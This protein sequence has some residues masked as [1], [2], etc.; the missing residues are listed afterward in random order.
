[1][2]RATLFVYEHPET[3]GIFRIDTSHLP[4][5]TPKS[6]LSDIW[7]LSHK[8]MMVLL[9][10][11][12]INLVTIIYVPWRNKVDDFGAECEV[13]LFQYPVR[14]TKN[15]RLVLSWLADYK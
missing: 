2:P 13:N 10:K 3:Y 4:R 1:M 14:K 8:L 15:G 11:V 5:A 7:P 9:P 12:L 6:D